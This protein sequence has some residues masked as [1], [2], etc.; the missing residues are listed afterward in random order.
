MSVAKAGIRSN[1]LC[2]SN[3][4]ECRA[5]LRTSPSEP[6]TSVVGSHGCGPELPTILTTDVVYHSCCINPVD[7]EF[8]ECGALIDLMVDWEL[9]NA[10]LSRSVKVVCNEVLNADVGQD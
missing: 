1:S 5:P 4:S 9:G 2:L 7:A 6:T 8:G 10:T 3:V